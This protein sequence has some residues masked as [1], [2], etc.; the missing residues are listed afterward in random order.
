MVAEVERRLRVSEPV[1]KFITVRID[2]N[3][4]KLA[5]IQALRATQSGSVR[6]LSP[7]LRQMPKRRRAGRRAAAPAPTE[8][9]QADCLTFTRPRALWREAPANEIEE[10]DG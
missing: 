5:K 1:I 6:R 2:E 10:T 3:R 4:K 7:P 8:P 9:T